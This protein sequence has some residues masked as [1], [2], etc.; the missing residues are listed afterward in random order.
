MSAEYGYINDKIILDKKLKEN[1]KLP[2]YKNS[3][4]EII[5]LN[6]PFEPIKKS[7]SR[8]TNIIVLLI[9]IFIF[10][11][12]F[13]FKIE[14]VSGIVIDYTSFNFYFVIGVILFQIF[15][16]TLIY[17]S[18]RQKSLKKKFYTSELTNVMAQ[19]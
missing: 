2:C 9:I 1:E 13:K 8:N 6:N 11:F 18:N 4:G 10:L 15:I 14:L 12:S 17:F 5:C 3:Y 19:K 7:L 16:F